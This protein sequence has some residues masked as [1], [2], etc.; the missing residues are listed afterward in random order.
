M[1]T[2]GYGEKDSFLMPSVVLSGGQ[3]GQHQAAPLRRVST[4]RQGR[5]VGWC[6]LPVVLKTSVEAKKNGFGSRSTGYHPLPYYAW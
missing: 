6:Y 2:P 5:I 1:L 4:Y 3:V